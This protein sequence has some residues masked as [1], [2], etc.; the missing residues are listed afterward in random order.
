MIN[1]I[2]LNIHNVTKITRSVINGGSSQNYWLELTIE[3]ANGEMTN[4]SLWGKDQDSLII[5]KEEI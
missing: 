5:Q 4:I 2:D 3:S 1:N